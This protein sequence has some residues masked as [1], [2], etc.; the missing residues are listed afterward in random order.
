[1]PSPLAADGEHGQVQSFRMSV[2]VSG[3]NGGQLARCPLN[4]TDGGAIF[5]APC[6]CGLKILARLRRVWAGFIAA[7]MVFM[8]G[9]RAPERAGAAA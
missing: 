6:G 5:A 4:G 3:P 2:Q 7:I 8:T 9:C 1:M